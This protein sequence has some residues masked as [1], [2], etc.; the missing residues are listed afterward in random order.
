MHATGRYFRHTVLELMEADHGIK[1]YGPSLLHHWYR[2]D[3]LRVAVN[4]LDR[5]T[6][7]LMIMAL[8]RPAS[9][10]LAQEFVEGKVR[11]EYAARVRGR[12]PE[13]VLIMDEVR[14]T[15]VW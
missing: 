14:E 10:D 12:F 6:S 7:G 3:G 5:L 15:E 1:C 11:K 4:R 13:Y 8:S 2:N 9:R